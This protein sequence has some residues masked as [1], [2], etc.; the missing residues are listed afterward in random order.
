VQH[1]PASGGQRRSLLV[2]LVAVACTATSSGLPPAEGQDV[3]PPA[4]LLISVADPR[5]SQLVHRSVRGAA[6]RL[7]RSPM[8]RELL[9]DFR[10]AS[11]DPLAAELGKLGQDPDVYL[12]GLVYIDGSSHRR[13]R[14]GRVL[15]FTGPGWRVVYVCPAF[16]DLE[17]RPAVAE[18]ILIHE[19]LHT[20]GLGENPPTSRVIQDQVNARC[21]V[22]R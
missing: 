19:A 21:L 17:R 18:A 22:P 14:N 1:R 12:A 10:T 16:L 13:C 6:S 5:T 7:R 2:T 20:L 9:R 4:A 11:G 8:C 3:P 15:A